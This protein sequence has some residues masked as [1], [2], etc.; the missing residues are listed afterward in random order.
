LSLKDESGKYIEIYDRETYWQVLHYGFNKE[1]LPIG[2]DIMF[3][4]RVSE[5]G[6]FLTNL[7]G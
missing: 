1:Y 4:E 7:L 6:K 2:F 3:Q 5:Y